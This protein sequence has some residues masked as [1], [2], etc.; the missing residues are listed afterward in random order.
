VRGA[1]DD[2]RSAR[3]RRRGAILSD[4]IDIGVGGEPAHT[5]DHICALYTGPDERDAVLL[6]YIRSALRSGDKCVCVVDS[7]E[8]ADLLARLR[9]D[10]D[11]DLA[12]CLASRQFDLLRAADTTMRSGRFCPADMAGFWKAFIA[13]TMNSRKYHRV[14]AASETGLSL[15]DLPDWREVVQHESEMNRMLPL[16]PQVLLCLYDLEK[17]G[18]AFLVDLMSMHPRLLINGRLTENPYYLAPDVWLAKQGG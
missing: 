17:V 14:R 15:R 1:W 3:R 7:T 10:T 12:E 13:G 11:I 2:G 16:Y 5:G 18:G 4:A 8:P 9:L 6:P